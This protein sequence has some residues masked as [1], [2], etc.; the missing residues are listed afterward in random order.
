MPQAVRQ[1]S[2]SGLTERGGGPPPCDPLETCPSPCHWGITTRM[3]HALALAV[4]LGTAA[5]LGAHPHI[6]IDTGLRLSFDAAG[7]L[8]TVEVTWIY[9]PLYSLLVTEDMRLDPDFDG[10]LTQAEIDQLT[11]FDMQWVEGFNGDLEIRQEGALLPL[12][13]PMEYTASFAEGQITTTHVRQVE[14]MTA[15]KPLALKPYDLTYY[16][17]YDVT[18]PTEIIGSDAC[19]TRVEM[20]DLTSGLEQV[21][22]QLEALD[23]DIDPAD[24][25][26]PDI[27]AKLAT[28]VIVTCAAS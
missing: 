16:T 25:G 6:F 5:P 8:Q 7:V 27:G 18:L 13:G 19:R 12:S 17:A 14:G 15:G 1:A 3:K 22:A 21:R 20:P 28:T 23:P 10:V 11:G 26:F 2:G 9:D 24:V 4:T